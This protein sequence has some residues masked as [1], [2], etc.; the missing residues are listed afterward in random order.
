[1]NRISCEKDET[2]IMYVDVYAFIYNDEYICTIHVFSENGSPIKEDV[3]SLYGGCEL[4]EEVYTGIKGSMKCWLENYYASDN[5]WDYEIEILFSKTSP[6]EEALNMNIFSDKSDDA[7]IMHQ[8]KLGEYKTVDS[9]LDSE[10]MKEVTKTIKGRRKPSKTK[11]IITIGGLILYFVVVF[12]LIRIFDLTHPHEYI[13][14]SVV[15]ISIPTGIFEGRKLKRK[16][17]R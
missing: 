7:V 3:L 17:K 15:P 4:T 6:V 16:T 10:R 9:L 11:V 14:V 8:H 13:T 12:S 1:M 2:A 5:A